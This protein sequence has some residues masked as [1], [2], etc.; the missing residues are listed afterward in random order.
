MDTRDNPKG[1]AYWGAGRDP[2][3]GYDRVILFDVPRED[4]VSLGQL[5]HANVGRF[6]YEP[7]Y[8]IGNSYAN[9]RIEQDEW[10]SSIS[11][12]LTGK[13]PGSFNI[14]D[15]SYLVNEVLWDSYIFSTIPQVADNRDTASESEPDDAHFEALRTNQ[16]LLP[17]PRFLPYEPAGSSFDR[18]TLQDSTDAFHYNAGHVMVDGAFNI[19][20][21]SVDAWEAFLSGTRGLA[22]QKVNGMGQITDFES[23]EG[24]RFPRVKASF[25][26]PVE[27]T[28]MDENHWIGFR[29]LTGEEVRELAGAIVDEVRE[30]GPFLSMAEFVNR[31]LDSGIHGQS[32]ALQAALDKTLNENTD[33]NYSASIN[34]TDI[35]TENTQAAGFPGQLL[36]GDILQALSPYMT[37]HSDTFTIRAYGESLSP[38]GTKIRSQAWCEAVVQRYPDPVGSSATDALTELADPSSNFGRRFRIVSFAWLDPNNI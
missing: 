38:D 24:V 7:S 6:S 11:D 1:Y 27:K 13:I 16:T 8:I 18:A 20:S 12:T 21:T 19:N 28:N 35:P 5:Q 36:Q 23:V 15:A 25:G 9:L 2:V 14:Y 34:N 4:L 26:G 17:N 31:K 3:D 22:Y 29:S 33:P 37:V 10:K 30:R 32:G